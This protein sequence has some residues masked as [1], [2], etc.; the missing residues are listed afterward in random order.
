MDIYEEMA[1][2]RPVPFYIII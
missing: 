2:N 1:Y